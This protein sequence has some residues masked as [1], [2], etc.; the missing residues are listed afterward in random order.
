MAEFLGN[1]CMAGFLVF[2]LVLWTRT[3]NVVS[4]NRQMRDTGNFHPGDTHMLGPVVIAL[5]EG[6]AAW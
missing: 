6:S 3:V 5:F 2:E 4:A 1:G